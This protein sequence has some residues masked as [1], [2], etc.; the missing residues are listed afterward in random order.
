[1]HKNKA[2]AMKLLRSRIFEAEQRR[3]QS[4]NAATKSGLFGSGDRSERIRTYN[5]PQ[6]RITDHR[7]NFSANGIETMMNGEQLPQFVEALLSHD[8]DSKVKALESG[9][10]S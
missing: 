8:N 3:T 1:M 10:L 5:F 4:E 6:N 2:K 9:N 7:I